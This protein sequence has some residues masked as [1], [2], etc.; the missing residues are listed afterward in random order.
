MGLAEQFHDRRCGVA[1]LV[2]VNDRRRFRPNDPDH[3]RVQGAFD[4]RHVGGLYKLH[5]DRVGAVNSGAGKVGGFGGW[6]I[7]QG[8]LAFRLGP[9]KC[10]HAPPGR[11]TQSGIFRPTAL[12]NCPY[13]NG[14]M[15]S[16]ESSILVKYAD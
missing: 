9:V 12:I 3:G 14:P 10:S 11:P 4:R 6:M 16:A 5:C 2:R 13:G 1:E 7:G 15:H 8:G